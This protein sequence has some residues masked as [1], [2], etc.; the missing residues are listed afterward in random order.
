MKKL[1]KKLLKIKA[2]E[3]FKIPLYKAKNFIY[4]LLKVK[5]KELFKIPLNV[6]AKKNYKITKN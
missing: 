4:I 1:F 3:L 6:K 2:K 5:A